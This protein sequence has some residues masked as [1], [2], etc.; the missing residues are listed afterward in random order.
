MVDVNTPNIQTDRTK[1]LF[2]RTKSILETS[3]LQSDGGY[4]SPERSTSFIQDLITGSAF[5]GMTRWVTMNSPQMQIDKIGINSRVLHGAN[6]AFTGSDPNYLEARHLE[7]SKWVT[8]TI[9]HIDL[10]TKEL[11]GVLPIPYEVVEDNI[12]RG[13]LVN[14]LNSMTA[15]RAAQ[16]LQELVL[17]GDTSISSVTDDLLCKA[18]GAFKRIS[19]SIVDCAGTPFNRRHVA[20]A[21]KAIDEAYLVKKD[22]W[23]IYVPLSTE[24]DY[25]SMRADRMTSLGDANEEGRLPVSILG[26]RMVGIPGMTRGSALMINPKNIIFGIQRQI[27]VEADKDIRARTMYFVY[28]L[29]CDVQVEE[30]R[31]ACKF[32]NIGEDVTTV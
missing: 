2:S 17:Y 24:T 28:T 26:Y 30:T 1:D 18:D 19:S 8:P 31:A 5:L 4:L 25:R 27:R 10:S 14:T 29:R 22:T 3:D 13:Q 16:D 9:G 7:S 20:R 12:E 6:T 32:T 15:A 21:E 23:G 11:I